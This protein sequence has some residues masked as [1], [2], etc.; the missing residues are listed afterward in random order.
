MPLP[1]CLLSAPSRNF[2]SLFCTYHALF[3]CSPCKKSREDYIC[4]IFP[5]SEVWEVEFTRVTGGWQE[6][7]FTGV[8]S[9]GLTL[10]KLSA[11]KLGEDRPAFGSTSRVNSPHR[12]EPNCQ[13]ELARVFSKSSL[14]ILPGLSQPSSLQRWLLLSSLQWSPFLQ[15]LF[16]LHDW[17]QK[18]TN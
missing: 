4:P 13:P 1:V 14:S 16:F 15:A 2:F 18:R 12:Q 17:T 10:S 8:A 3:L 6:S 11:G 9:L 7:S 5:E